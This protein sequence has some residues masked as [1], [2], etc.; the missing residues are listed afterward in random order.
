MRSGGRSLLRF[1]SVQSIGPPVGIDRQSDAP[2][3]RSV[4]FTLR[5]F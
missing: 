4:G 5:E 3:D 2:R 1:R